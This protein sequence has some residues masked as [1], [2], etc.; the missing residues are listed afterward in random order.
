MSPRR[1]HGSLEA[2]VLQLLWARDAAQNGRQIRD[3][4]ADNGDPL[5]STTVLTVLAR[6]EKKGL[7]ERD[8]VSRAYCATK[9]DPAETADS[10]AEVLGRS[11]DRRAVLQRFTGALRAEDLHVLR[12]ALDGSGNNESG[13][14]RT[15]GESVA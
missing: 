11:S 12:A 7:V 15:T 1:A 5:A 3:A 2:N 9:A 10:M 8:P 13:I 4:L 6:L 14:D